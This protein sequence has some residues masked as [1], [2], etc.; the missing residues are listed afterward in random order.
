M[1]RRVKTGEHTGDRID[2][3]VRARI[4]TGKPDIQPPPASRCDTPGHVVRGEW[5]GPSRYHGDGGL[6]PPTAGPVRG[7]ARALPSASMF[8]KNNILPPRRRSWHFF[9]L[10]H[11]ESPFSH[12]G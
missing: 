4:K 2:A 3:V 11:K 6:A 5:I 7:L 9:V 10:L 12:P 1:R 8:R